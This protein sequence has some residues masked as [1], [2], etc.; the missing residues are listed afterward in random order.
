MGSKEL[1][2]GV[3]GF[4]GLRANPL[5]HG[6]LGGSWVVVIGLYVPCHGLDLIMV[7]LHIPHLKLPMNREPRS[8]RRG[9]G[10]ARV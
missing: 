3:S 8:M 7:T 4:E 6:A 10:V 5:E 1:G 9:R 2:F